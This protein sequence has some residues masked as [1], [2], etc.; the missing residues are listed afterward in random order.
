MRYQ[1]RLGFP[2][3]QFMF[4]A[5]RG[6]M[7]AATAHNVE[8]TNS[9]TGWDDFNILWCEALNAFERGECTHFAMLHSD[10]EPEPAWIDKLVAEL[11]RLDAGLVSV[12]APIKDNRGLT[13]SGI[14]DV[15]DRWCPLRRFTVREIQGFPE[16]FNADDAGYGGQP[17]LHNTGCWCCDL[18]KPEWFETF[19]SGDL[20]AMF[21][22]P[23]HVYRDQKTGKW[24]SACE[25]EDWYFSR[26]VFDLGISSYIT[27][28]VSLTHRGVQDYPNNKAWGLYEHDEDTRAKW[29]VDKC[30]IEST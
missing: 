26:Q 16:T 9:G 1:I 25:S 4:G 23:R 21:D 27:R 12:P 29:D 30:L 14:G 5:V 15:N 24:C 8:V 6:V 28:K 10:I 11:D 22:F 17:L 19:S 18:R 20:R 3:N 7:T 13:S 2:G